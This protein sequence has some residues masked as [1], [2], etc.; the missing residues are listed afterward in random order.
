MAKAR[1][2]IGNFLPAEEMCLAHKDKIYCYAILDN[3]NDNT[4]YNNPT[5][6]FPFESYDNK[7]YI[8]MAYVYKLNAIFIIPMKTGKDESRIATFEQVYTKFESLGHKPKLHILYNECN[9]CI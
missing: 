5:G 7:E 6:R 9:R 4:L 3:T 2:N 8:F 1:H